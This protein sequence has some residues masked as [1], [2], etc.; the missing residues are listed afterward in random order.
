MKFYI[1]TTFIVLSFVIGWIFITQIPDDG[2][3]AYIGIPF[4]CSI[5]CNWLAILENG[6]IKSGG[7][8][9]SFLPF[10]GGELIPI[11]DKWLKPTAPSIFSALSVNQR[12]IFSTNQRPIL[13]TFSLG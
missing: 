12:P 8:W 13:S 9:I 10:F 1:S 6:A 3:I 4:L 11:K 5:I 7:S 2:I